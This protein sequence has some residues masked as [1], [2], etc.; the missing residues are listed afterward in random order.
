MAVVRVH[1]DRYVQS[2][3]G[4]WSFQKSSLWKSGSENGCRGVC[5]HV[6]AEAEPPLLWLFLGPDSGKALQLPRGCW[7]SHLG[8]LWCG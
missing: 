2:T 1:T 3:E 8:F 4:I 5:E 6:A 7:D